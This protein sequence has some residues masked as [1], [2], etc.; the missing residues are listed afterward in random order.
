VKTD[1]I[2]LLGTL[3]QA[4]STE[5][6]WTLAKDNPKVRSRT[7]MKKMLQ[8]LKE[9]GIA[10]TERLDSRFFGFRLSGQAAREN[11]IRAAQ[12]ATPALPEEVLEEVVEKPA[13]RSF[14]S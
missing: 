8:Q 3:P 2:N 9:K 5:D 7:F 4:T 6:I 1:L 12:H 10:K 13:P 11:R 14:W